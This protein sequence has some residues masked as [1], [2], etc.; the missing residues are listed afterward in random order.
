MFRDFLNFVREVLGKDNEIVSSAAAS[1]EE[2]MSSPFYGYFIISWLIF[3]W[4]FLYIAFFVDQE[5]IFEKTGLL[6]DEY[7]WLKLPV[8]IYG[9]ILQFV[10]YPFLLTSLAVFV[11]PFVTRLFFWKNILNKQAL[12]KIQAKQNSQKVE[13]IK[14]EVSVIDAEREKKEAE[15]KTEIETPE[16]IWE[17][18][19]NNFRGAVIF[20]EFKNVLLNY[21]RKGVARVNI[22]TGMIAFMDLAGLGGVDYNFAVVLSP[23]GK[24]F[25]K[26]YLEIF[27]SILK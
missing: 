1:I 7:I 27:P 19:F 9:H 17:K 2:R 15:K 5:K 25:A 10:F 26:K 21:Y 20:S 18:D 3:N 11:F 4:K 12:L 14:S 6:R 8:D 13:E 24:F 22:S 16:V 23:K